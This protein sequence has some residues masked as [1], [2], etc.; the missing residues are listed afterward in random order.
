MF[1][2]TCIHEHRH[3][4]TLNHTLTVHFHTCAAIPK[5]PG[6]DALTISKTAGKQLLS[7]Q[8]CMYVCV[9]V[10]TQGQVNTN[11]GEKVYLC[12]EYESVNP[13]MH[14]HTYI[15]T[16]MQTQVQANTNYG[17]EVYLC[18][19]H[20]SVNPSIHT[21]THTYNRAHTGSGQHQ[22]RRGNI[23]MWGS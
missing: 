23:P 16:I 13:C 2:C 14:T 1:T 7:F 15:H 11:C 20:E 18:G 9:C 19:D 4:Y 3:T 17:E 21:H 10:Y 8:V 22:L 12:V 6:S 5:E